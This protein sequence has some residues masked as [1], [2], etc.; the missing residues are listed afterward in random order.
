[1]TRL[2]WRLKS[3][4]TVA[5][6][7]RHELKI[8]NNQSMR[9]TYAISLSS[10]PDSAPNFTSSAEDYDIFCQAD[11]E[12]QRRIM[13]AEEEHARKLEM[14]YKQAQCEADRAQAKKEVR[15]ISDNS[16]SQV[17]CWPQ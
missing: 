10:C 3:S 1:M 14:E 13:T 9:Y 2:V 17:F 4:Q 16:P 7:P 15:Q 8:R 5:I 6:H 11:R 12:K